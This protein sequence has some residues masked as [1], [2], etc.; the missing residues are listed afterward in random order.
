MKC[1]ILIA[2]IYK[3][4]YTEICI[5]IL[6]IERRAEEYGRCRINETIIKSIHY[7]RDWA[8]FIGKMKNIKRG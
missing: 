4:N 7:G 1:K 8:R 3:C 6:G 5:Y 2:Y